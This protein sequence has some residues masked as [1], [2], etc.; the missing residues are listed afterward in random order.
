MAFLRENRAEVLSFLGALL[1]TGRKVS[2]KPGGGSLLA[3]AALPGMLIRKLWKLVLLPFALEGPS[4]PGGWAPLPECTPGSC[5]ALPRGSP[6]ARVPRPGC[7]GP[8]R[9]VSRLMHELGMP[10][11][12]PPAGAGAGAGAGPSCLLPLSS[13]LIFGILGSSEMSVLL[14]AGLGACPSPALL[15]GKLPFEVLDAN[16]KGKACLLSPLNWGL[17]RRLEPG[18]LTFDAF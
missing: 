11:C 4:G 1:S 5:E 6:S 18:L 17:S 7:P 3:C 2:Q 9:P 16:L 12:C 10:T 8:S 13:L 15:E 14:G